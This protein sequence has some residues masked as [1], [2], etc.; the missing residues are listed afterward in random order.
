MSD[1][2]DI[3][4]RGSTY[5]PP[6]DLNPIKQRALIVAAVAG[7][8]CVLGGFLDPTQF[9]RSYLVAF[10]FWLSI[11]L[12]CLAIMMLQ[13][14]ASGAWG[15]MLR[16]TL[17]AAART[18][19][20]LA[21]LFVPIVIGIPRLYLWANPDAVR[22]DHLL[23][24][25]AAY[26]NVPF[27]IGRAVFYFAVWTG[28]AYL[29]SRM[30]RTQ[31]QRRDP[32]LPA[33]MRK[34]SAVGLMLYCLTTT[35]ASID[36][37]M[38]LR[39]HW[40][41]TIYGVYVVGGQAVSAMSFSILVSL[42]LVNRKPMAGAVLPRHFHDFGKLL[43]GF[44]MLWAYFSVSQFIVIW[45]GNLPEEITWYRDRLL[46]GW[47][48]VSLALVLL[49]FALPFFLL[50]SRDLK[51]S[52][53]R[54]AMVA[55]LLL[56]MRWVDLYWLVLPAFYPERLVIHW[57]DF[58]APV[59]LGGIWVWLFTRELMSRPLLPVHEPLLKEALSDG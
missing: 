9:F 23:H 8:A 18:L 54:L 32:E 36:W 12:G 35:F 31:D 21:V 51:R 46:G 25:K 57:M 26:L 30:S 15:V 6:R 1:E 52:A 13:H 49:H 28:L 59:A 16:R 22:A 56:V 53:P 29:L 45:S 43:L 7:A 14:V 38:S 24:H 33:R 39:P 40:Y 27:F 2:R 17:E 47:K 3:E 20:I 58:V 50:L 37:L 11:A 44:V 42:F 48:Y 4:P 41:S 34:V 55:G 10:V 5:D 19:P